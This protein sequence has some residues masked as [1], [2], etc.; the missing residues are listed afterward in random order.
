[1]PP[2]SRARVVLLLTVL[3]TNLS[4]AGGLGNLQHI[5]RPPR[6]EQA[7]NQP[8]ELRLL[9]PTARNPLG[10]AGVRVWLQV[11]NP[12]P[13]GFMLSSIDADLSVEGNRAATGNF[14]LGLPLTA[15]QTSVV[16]LDLSI[17]FADVPALS[18]TLRRLASGGTAPYQMDGTVGIDAGR[19]GTPTFGPMRL[20][21]GEVHV[22]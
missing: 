18:R 21:T 13:F 19:F 7:P 10:G 8:A 17:S 1:M 12:N 9:G 11:T 5:I 15:G 16:P 2:N 22:R 3:A 4:C 6:L 14:P 20:I